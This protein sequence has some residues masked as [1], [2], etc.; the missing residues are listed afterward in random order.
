MLVSEVPAFREYWYPLAYSA[1]IGAV[2]LEA[3]LFGEDLVLW[4]PANGEPVR[5]AVNECPHRGA[6]LSQGWLTDGCLVCP[7]HGWRFDGSGA[8]IGIPSQEP[9]LPIPPRAHVQS[10]L[11][12]ERYGLAWVCIGMPRAD[13]PLLEELEAG[14]TLIH[15]IKEIW[16][17]SAPRMIDNALDVAHVAWVHKG[18]VGD[19]DHPRLSDFRVERDAETMR[20]SVSYQSRVRGT[21][22]ANT[23]LSGVVNRTTHAELVQPFV[24][25]GVLEYE[26]GLRHVLYRTCSPVDDSHTLLF[27]FIGRS[28]QPSPD[29]WDDIIAVDRAVQAEDRAILERINPDF[30]IDATSELHTRSDR[31][32]IEYRRIL[33]ELV[34]ESGAARSVARGRI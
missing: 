1:D 8:C 2:P 33:A 23:G 18:T 22:E 5:A 13:I 7:Y 15:E 26:T 24:F 17:A 14:Y 21:Q 29:K 34:A 31:M 10:V 30:P 20:F 16:S 27:Q 28:D 19:P 25:R 6:R 9:S 3:R 12:G 32:T 4:R 11:A